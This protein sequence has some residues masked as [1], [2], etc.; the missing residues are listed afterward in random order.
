MSERNEVA[1]FAKLRQEYAED[2]RSNRLHAIIYGMKGTGK[3]TV[4]ATGR[5]PILFHMFDPGGEKSIRDR[6]TDPNQRIYV[7]A[8][9]GEEDP[10]HPTAFKAWEAEFN[11][12]FKAGAFDKLGTYVLDSGTTWSDAAMNYILYAKGKPCVKPEWD[13]Y[14]IQQIT[15]RDW[16]KRIL[17]L[18]CDVI[19]TGHIDTEK[20]EISGTLFRDVMLTGK[21]RVKV[22]L[23]VDEVYMTIAKEA[24]SSGRKHSLITQPTDRLSACTRLGANG[25]FEAIEEPDIKNL[26]R[27]AGLPCDDL[28]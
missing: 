1:E 17:S 7:D 10:W 15:M 24:G 4:A 3:T 28:A 9:F 16:M 23:L 22:P 13:H 5:Q 19:L 14:H 18:P 2:P 6:L 20:D 12:L 26:L 8:Q 21:L 27:K 11:R 25:R